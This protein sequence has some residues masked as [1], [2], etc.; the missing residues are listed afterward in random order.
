MKFGWINFVGAAIVFLMMVPNI[1]YAK[2][3]K[4]EKNH[5]INHFM[6]IIDRHHQALRTEAC[7]HQKQII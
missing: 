2:K 3:N 1:I 4:D 6:N 5:C 7:R